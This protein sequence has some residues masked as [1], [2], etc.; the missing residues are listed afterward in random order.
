[1][2]GQRV[3]TAAGGAATYKAGCLCAAVKTVARLR[4]ACDLGR[5]KANDDGWPCN[6]F[7]FRPSQSWAVGRD[8]ASP[9]GAGVHLQFSLFLAQPSWLLHQT[10]RALSRC[11]CQESR[12]SVC[13]HTSTRHPC[14]SIAQVQAAS[15]FQGRSPGHNG[16]SCSGCSGSIPCFFGG[17]DVNGQATQ[18]Q[19]YCT[20]PGSS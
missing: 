5:G 13:I 7:H 10:G 18:I 8:E 16:T 4:Q 19:I 20:L 2:T 3:A 14:T 15:K 1:M 17:T 12:K 6:S 9:N 11:G